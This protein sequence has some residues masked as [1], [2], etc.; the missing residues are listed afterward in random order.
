MREPGLDRHEWESELQ[1]LE[2]ELADSPAESLP[3][4]DALVSRMLEETG[5][6][7][8]DPVVR[9]GDEREVVAE[10]LAAHELA[11]AV[12]RDDDNIS[13]GDVAAA[14]NGFRAVFDHLAVTRSDVDADI[15]PSGEVAE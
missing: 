13:P 4:L 8:G 2:P 12:E 5:Y 9:D 3:E 6:D 14:I 7:I 15:T 1:A 10:Y 11:Q